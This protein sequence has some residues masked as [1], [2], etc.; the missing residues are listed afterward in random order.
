MAFFLTG[1]RPINSTQGPTADPSTAAI[2]AELDSSQLGMRNSAGQDIGPASRT[3]SVNIWLGGS[4]GMYWAV[5]QATSTAI[6][7]GVV[8]D[9]FYPRT[10]SGQT[11]QFVRKFTLSPGHRLRVHHVSS[12]TGLADASLQAEELA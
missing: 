8:V 2:L 3:F 10:A 1:N 12:V 7:S 4:T 11:S 9:A 5:E 6:S